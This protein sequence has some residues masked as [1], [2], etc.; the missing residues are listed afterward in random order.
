ML[1]DLLTF[2]ELSNKARKDDIKTYINIARSF[3]DLA[4]DAIGADIPRII[5]GIMIVYTYVLAMLGGF[6]CVQQKP[7]LGGIGLLCVFLAVTSAYGVCSA[8]GLVF[9]PMHNIIPFLLMGIGI[10]DMFVIVQSHVNVEQSDPVWKTMPID[11][12]VGETLKHAGV[13]ITIT[14]VTDLVVFL[15]GG[16][17][18][19]PAL[20]SF[21]IF[22]AF[23]VFFVYI[24]QAVLF[25]AFLS[26]DIERI[27]QN[28]NGFF[29]C[30]SHK[31]QEQTEEEATKL[32]WWRLNPGKIFFEKYATILMKPVSKAVVLAVTAICLGFGI[33]G[34]VELKQ[35]FNPAWFLPGGSYL[36]GWLDQVEKY[37]PA[38]GEKVTINI[39]EIDYSQELWKVESLVHQLEEEKEIVTSVESWLTDFRSYVESN[40]L[41]QGNLEMFRRKLSNLPFP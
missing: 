15:I 17:T 22:C 5:G 27:R 11:K 3:S 28:R 19:L 26:L 30:I 36:L 1:Q 20:K 14:S 4:N 25:T 41:I 40:Q 18:V 32:S 21:C 13:A 35:E 2:S 8:M 39:G 16:S 10:D 38:S 7:F 34:V 29:P 12:I 24:L 6:D 33:Y 9:S 31:M 37:F 23:G